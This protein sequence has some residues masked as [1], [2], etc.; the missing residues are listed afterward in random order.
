[1]SKTR[2]WNVATLTWPGAATLRFVSMSVLR[3]EKHNTQELISWTKREAPN[4]WQELCNAKWKMR[5]KCFL[6]IQR[7]IALWMCFFLGYC[8]LAYP[9]AARECRKTKEIRW[10]IFNTLNITQSVVGDCTL[11]TPFDVTKGQ[12]SALLALSRHC[13]APCHATGAG[14]Y[15]NL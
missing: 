10:N 3:E 8:A 9:C 12:H 1:M 7:F 5:L 6:L 4:K 2:W 13:K 11:L 14:A 15:F